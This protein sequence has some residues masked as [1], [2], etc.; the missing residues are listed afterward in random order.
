MIEVDAQG[1]C[2]IYP[3]SYGRQTAYGNH[4]SFSP[5]DFILQIKLYSSISINRVQLGAI[6]KTKISDIKSCGIFFLE[7]AESNC[8]TFEIC[9]SHMVI[10]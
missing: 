2:E 7:Q 3:F 10:E 4:F 5:D 8:K 9:F 6:I 1:I